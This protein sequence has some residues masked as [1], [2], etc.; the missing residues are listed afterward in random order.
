MSVTSN[1]AWPEVLV[2]V[3]VDGDMCDEPLKA[4]SATVI[5]GTGLPLWSSSVTV[6]VDCVEP[7]AGTED[8][9]ACTLDWLTCGIPA[10]KVTSTVW[11]TVM[12]SVESVATSVSDSAVVSYTENEIWPSPVVDVICVPPELT[13]GITRAVGEA[14][15]VPVTS[16]ARVTVLPA[17]RSPN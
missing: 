7:S 11:A 2:T 10:V 8:G 16:A 1:V 13:A 9:L 5:P 6:I 14:F 4:A 15:E 3:P 12:L 17:R